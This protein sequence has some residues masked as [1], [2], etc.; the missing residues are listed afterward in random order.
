[1]PNAGLPQPR[2]PILVGCGDVTD[3]DTPIETGRS[4]Y[5]LIAEACRRAL[6]D[7]GGTGLAGAIDTVAMLRS[8]KD[9]SHRFETRLGGSTN[10]PKSIAN[11]LGLNAGRHLYTWNGGNMPQML[12]NQFAEQIAD[13]EMRAALVVGGEALRTQHGV[14]R[15]G[16]PVSWQEDPGGA[17]EQIGDPRRGWNDHEDR[18]NLRAAI[19]QYP[20]FENAIR[21]HRGRTLDDHMRAMGQLMAG[22]AQVAA[23]NPLATRRAGYA[24]ARI[25]TVDADNRWIGFPYPRLMVSNAFIDQAA[26][27]VMTSVGTARELGIPESKWV[28]L[29]GCADGHDH[30]Y[31]TERHDLHSSPAIRAVSR[32]ALD[33]AGKQVGDLKFLD[34]YSCFPS[35]IEIACEEL[36][37]AED[38]PRGLTVTGGL[39]YFGGPGNSYVVMSITEMMRRLRA[40][41]G[42]FGLVTAN[43]N[44]VTKHSCGVYSTAP[45]AGRWR[46]EDPARLQAQLDALPKAP[47][48]QQ[49]EGAATI[50]TYT[51]MHDKRGPAYS[52]LL[53]RLNATGERFI[54]NTPADAAV[55]QDLQAR[56]GLGRAGLVRHRDGLN[57]F[58]PA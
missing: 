11:R 29:H 17:P 27:F 24:A 55:L 26:A 33:M 45:Y 43:G 22:F 6:A 47:F 34:L 50:E 38:D 53:G 46:R 35:A 18:H 40:A 58:Y 28:Y 31:T 15:A 42:E 57:T 56:E 3:L 23:A 32:T 36:G 16:L 20:L 1:M 7:A 39:V 25:S 37:I 9:T 2:T 54:A 8:Y 49:A 12:V 13:G 19:T 21:G 44:W 5:D 30:W 4:P 52:V 10:P 41:P 48:A 14:E 51:V